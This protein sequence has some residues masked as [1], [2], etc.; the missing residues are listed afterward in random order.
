MPVAAGASA[1]FS[2]A[3]WPKAL[4]HE[5]APLCFWYSPRINPRR[6][7]FAEHLTGQL[8]HVRLTGAVNSIWRDK[9]GYAVPCRAE[10]SI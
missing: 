6:A 2:R 9:T 7:G 8:G 10:R 1:Q 3:F 4:C 5:R